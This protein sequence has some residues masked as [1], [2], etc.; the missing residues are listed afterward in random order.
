MRVTIIHSVANYILSKTFLMNRIKSPSAHGF[1]AYSI[2]SRTYR[3]RG[4]VL[5]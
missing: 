1:Y 5:L 4:M 3:K 2:S